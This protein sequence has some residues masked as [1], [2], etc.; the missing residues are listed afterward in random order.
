M[1]LRPI[2]SAVR[3][4]KHPPQSSPVGEFSL[5]TSLYCAVKAHHLDILEHSKEEHRLSF[6]NQKDVVCYPMHAPLQR[7]KC[8]DKLGTRVG[9]APCTLPATMMLTHNKHST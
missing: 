9:K 5:A 6:G 2:G 1:P 7:I 3:S 4:P 8:S